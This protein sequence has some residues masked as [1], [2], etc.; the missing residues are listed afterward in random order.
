MH[1][2]L[3]PVLKSTLVFLSLTS[4]WACNYDLGERTLDMEDATTVLVER[5][6]KATD[7]GTETP[8]S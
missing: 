1:T 3:K 2:P 5:N 6:M 4:L 7:S 8:A